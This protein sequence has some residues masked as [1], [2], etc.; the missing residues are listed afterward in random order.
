[1]SGISDLNDKRTTRMRVIMIVMVTVA[2]ATLCLSCSKDTERPIN[3]I[4]STSMQPFAEMLSQEFNKR[5]P[6]ANVEVQGG[7]STAGIEA[8]R[9]DIA[10][11][12]MCSRNLKKD[13][14]LDSV[15]IALDGLAIIVHQSNPVQ[16]LSLQQIQ[17]IFVGKTITDWSQVGGRDLPIRM[18]T[19]EE[20]SGTREAFMNLVMHKVRISRKALTQESNGAVRE[21]VRNDPAAIGYMSQGLVM[22]E[23]KILGLEKILGVNGIVPTHATVSSGEYPLVRPFLFVTNGKPIPKAQ[24]FIDFVLSEPGQTMLEMEGLVRAKQPVK[25]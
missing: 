17:D 4:G 22:G 25:P 2:M 15:T 23:A 8:V 20:G 19:R 18:I 7:G 1:M 16:Q 3:V 13:E 14:A 11:I 21:L 10:D 5:H 6:E 24:E 12:G 9:S